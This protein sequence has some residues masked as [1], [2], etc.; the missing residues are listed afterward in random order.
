MM[1]FQFDDDVLLLQL[2]YV[3]DLHQDNDRELSVGDKILMCN[4]HVIRH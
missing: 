4:V 3:G 1:K 2:S